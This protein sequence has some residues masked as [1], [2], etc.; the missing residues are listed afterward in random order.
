MQHRWL[1]RLHK[2]YVLLKTFFTILLSSAVG[3]G[4]ISAWQRKNWL[5]QQ[6][7]IEKKELFEARYTNASELSK[8]L[9][10][11]IIAS[12]NYLSILETENLDAIKDERE[13]YRA[14][15]FDW[16][17]NFTA[18]LHK[19]KA[20]FKTEPIYEFDDYVPHLLVEVENDLMVT[21]KLVEQK[22]IIDKGRVK[23]IGLNIRR[24][25][26]YSSEYFGCLYK[27]ADR[28]REFIENPEIIERNYD[29]LTT[30]YILK[31]IFKPLSIS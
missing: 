5:Y 6:K 17:A 22:K 21:R 16:N 31:N 8:I 3:Y 9:V 10:T 30:F 26:Q 28:D 23:N 7:I 1:D 24:I 19:L 11:R 15:V 27:I 25:N 2:R 18:I 14:V 29:D 4:I 13:K 12:Q 20:D